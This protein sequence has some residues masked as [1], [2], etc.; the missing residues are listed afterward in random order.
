MLL[1][2]GFTL[3]VRATSKHLEARYGIIHRRLL[4]HLLYADATV[5]SIHEHDDVAVSSSSGDNVEGMLVSSAPM[6]PSLPDPPLQPINPPISSEL[7]EEQLESL[8]SLEPAAAFV[9][10]PSPA[11]LAAAVEQDE[12]AET[13]PSTS[14]LVPAEE[15]QQQQQGPTAHAKYMKAAVGTGTVAREFIISLVDNADLDVTAHE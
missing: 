4:S 9:P 7:H 10:P 12:A 11:S 3:Q 8:S 15:I 14:P 5:I 13:I 1:L 2:L 6:P